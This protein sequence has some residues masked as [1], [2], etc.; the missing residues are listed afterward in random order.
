MNVA[1]DVCDDG[2]NNSADE[3]ATPRK[4]DKERH[5]A[6]MQAKLVMAAHHGK[7]RDW[8]RGALLHCLDVLGVKV[9]RIK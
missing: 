9:A 3:W 2:E 8:T 5:V 1:D 7:L 6:K 4:P